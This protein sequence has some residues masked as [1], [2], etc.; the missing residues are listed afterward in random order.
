MPPPPAPSVYGLGGLCSCCGGARAGR[1]G[2]PSVCATASHTGPCGR[3]GG[4]GVGNA[5]PA[6]SAPPFLAPRRGGT[7]GTSGRRSGQ[8]APPGSRDDRPVREERR[9]G[10]RGP[11]PPRDPSAPGR[12]SEFT[13][14]PGRVNYAVSRDFQVERFSVTLRRNSGLGFE[15]RP[16]SA[17]PRRFPKVV[18]A[19][20]HSRRAPGSRFP[21][22]AIKKLS[23]L[24]SGPRRP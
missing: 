5:A 6:S 14:S 20:G 11:S 1:P 3:A 21:S 13:A 18:F 9:C 12:C 23:L 16:S 22:L 10:W 15:H 17:A 19:R 24:K 7:W 8:W 4:A 2:S